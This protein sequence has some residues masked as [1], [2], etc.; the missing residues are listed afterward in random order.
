MTLPGGLNLYIS[1]PVM[2]LWSKRRDSMEKK[3]FYYITEARCIACGRCALVCPE[4]CIGIGVPYEIDQSKCVLCGTCYNVCPKSAVE[5]QEK[6][7][8]E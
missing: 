1:D 4:S 3:Q 7:P 6:A 5:K 2:V 8:L